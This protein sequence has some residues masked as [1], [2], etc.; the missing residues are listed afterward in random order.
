MTQYYWLLNTA[1]ACDKSSLV[2]PVWDKSRRKKSAG[3]RG[4]EMRPAELFLDVDTDA[5][6][7]VPAKS[8][9]GRRRSVWHLKTVVCRR[10][11]SVDR[12]HNS[13]ELTTASVYNVLGMHIFRR[14]PSSTSLYR[15]LT[16]PL[17]RHIDA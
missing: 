14:S 12:S 5:S 13:P 4:I 6:W 1:S 15:P 16:Q 3:R 9:P 7:V 17:D 8:V 2:R 10:V 11:G